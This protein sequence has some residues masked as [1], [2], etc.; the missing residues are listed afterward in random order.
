MNRRTFA[1]HVGAGMAVLAA[2]GTAGIRLLDN[3]TQIAVT[4]NDFLVSDDPLLSGTRRN[5]AMLDALQARGNLKAAVF[6][7]GQYVDDP[8]TWPLL[9][10]W[11]EAGHLIG[12]HTYSCYVYPHTDFGTFTRDLLRNEGLL[13]EF[14]MYRRI[15]RFPCLKEGA[16]V[17][18]RDR[19]RAFLRDHGYR[20]GH[21]TIDAADE[22]IDGRLR[23]RLERDPDADLSPYREYYLRH[24]WDRAQ[25]YDTLS[26]K[27]LGRSIRHTLLLHHNVLNGLFLANVFDM[28]AR[29]GWDLIDAADAF[30][31]PAYRAE[32]DIIPAGGSLLRQLASASGRHERELPPPVGDGSLEQSHMDAL[33]L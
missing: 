24:L 23:K 13:H 9:A 28:F 11:D 8:V 2:S 1:R 5:E 26:R 17:E 18:Q 4:I 30:E 29:N 33:G 6:V 7:T 31:D 25:H 19:M 10:R 12:N 22:Y 16:T 32:P 27:V 20:N 21:A 3:R 14:P 15:F